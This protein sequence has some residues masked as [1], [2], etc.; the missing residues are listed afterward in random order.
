MI[1]LD[2][3]SRGPQEFYQNMPIEDRLLIAEM[4]ANRGKN[5]PPTGKRRPSVSY[6]CMNFTGPVC[7]L[8]LV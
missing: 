8:L 7:S 1:P 6:M 2:S 3:P 4:R 5:P